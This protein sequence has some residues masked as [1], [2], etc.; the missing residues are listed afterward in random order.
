MSLLPLLAVWIGAGVVACGR[1]GFGDRLYCL[2]SVYISASN[3]TFVVILL[4]VLNWWILWDLNLIFH[5]HVEP[6]RIYCLYS[7]IALV[8]YVYIYLF[9]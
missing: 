2:L 5:G 4:V 3:S 9:T 7:D 6:C 1:I 8:V